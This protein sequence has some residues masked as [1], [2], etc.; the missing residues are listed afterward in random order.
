MHMGNLAVDMDTLLK[1]S[2]IVIATCAL[3]PETTNIFNA[4]TFEKMKSNA[5]LVNTARGACV[6]QDALV[7]ALKT[8]QIKVWL[9]CL[10]LFGSNLC[11]DTKPHCLPLLF[12]CG[13]FRS[14][15]LLVLT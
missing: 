15:R 11:T 1:E 10:F 14:S 7:T 13:L 3:T 4:E 9:A 8:G 5:I 6:D 2:D 12:A